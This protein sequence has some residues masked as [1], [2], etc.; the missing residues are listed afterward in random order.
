MSTIMDEGL[1][2]ESPVEVPKERMLTETQVADI[3]KKEKHRAAERARL[4]YE[5][6]LREQAPLQ[7]QN[8]T[9]AGGID[10]DA[11]KKEILDNIIEEGNRLREEAER[12]QM[13]KHLQ[14]TA[15]QYHHK[16]KKGSQLFDDYEEVMADF[17]PSAFPALIRLAAPM[18]NLSEVMYE[19]ANNP[20]KLVEINDLAQRSPKLA[21]K[22]LQKLSASIGKNL[23]AK[24]NVINAPAPLSK[25]KPSSVGADTGK[26]TLRDLKK[27]DFLRG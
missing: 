14:D 13:M 4:E 25:I 16:I 17:D 9:S 7:S 27:Q 12:E 18:E 19:L 26:M 24:A 10:K 21:E 15:D 3:V 5:A 8:E 22:Q 23:E 6:K 11:L 20:S 1:T 2:G